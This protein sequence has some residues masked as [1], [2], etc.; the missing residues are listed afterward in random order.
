MQYTLSNVFKKKIASL[1]NKELIDCNVTDLSGVSSQVSIWKDQRDG[2]LFPNFDI[3]ANGSVVEGELYTNPGT[4]KSTIYPPRKKP[5]PR[6]A[7]RD[8]GIK[9]AQE[10][11]AEGIDRSIGRNEIMWAKYGACEILAKHPSYAGLKREE[12]IKAFQ[13]LVDDIYSYKP[14]LSVKDS[15]DIQASKTVASAQQEADDFDPAKMDYPTEDI[16]F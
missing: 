12:L 8:S 5:A 15:D 11:K 3:L 9:E 10:R 14:N 13:T 16:P 4:G 6:T 7:T 1:G 2:N